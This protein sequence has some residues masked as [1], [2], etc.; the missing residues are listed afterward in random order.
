MRDQEER[1]RHFIVA[2]D[3]KNLDEPA[4]GRRRSG[5]ASTRRDEYD[6]CDDEDTSQSRR[7]TLRDREYEEEDERRPSKRRPVDDFDE[8]NDDSETRKAPFLVRVFAWA[9]LLAILFACG[10]LGANYFFN[11]A[12]KKNSTRVGSVVGTTAEVKQT[13]PA[14][15]GGVA[16]AGSAVY[17]I[18]IPENGKFTE[19]PADIQKG[20]KESDLAR[21]LAMYIDSLKETKMLN[22][23]VK[24]QNIFI[25]GDWL[26]VDMNGAF[27]A[28]MKSLGKNKGAL[29]I[30][31]MLKTVSENFPPVK[32]VKFYIDG[33]EPNLSAPVDLTK[34][35]GL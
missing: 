23:D 6:R 26:Y 18:Y 15:T 10:Y 1:V 17:T 2:G 25:S 13:I 16:V 22:N 14:E 7:R 35:W 29:V 34:P 32:K 9:A 28:S 27:Q 33:K 30:T 19:R 24:T 31:G 4:V 21:I 11:W 5:L 20:T 12:D 3:R 8:Y